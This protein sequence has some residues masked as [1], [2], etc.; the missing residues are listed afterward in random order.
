MS[1]IWES[2][3]CGGVSTSCNIKKPKLTN[4]VLQDIVKEIDNSGCL[5]GRIIYDSTFGIAQR[6]V[7]NNLNTGIRV[8]C[9]ELYPMDSRGKPR[10]IFVDEASSIASLL[11][12]RFK[13]QF[14]VKSGATYMLS[15]NF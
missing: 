10:A 1:K 6:I 9:I 15:S 11:G 8:F 14:Y 4:K 5:T 12:K 13:L 7:A 3:K 2:Q